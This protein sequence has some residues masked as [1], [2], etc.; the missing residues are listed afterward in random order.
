M[1]SDAGSLQPVC[2]PSCAWPAMRSTFEAR[3]MAAP[4]A[5]S[6]RR[7]FLAGSTA[8]ALHGLRYM[9]RRHGPH[10]T[11]RRPHAGGCRCWLDAS[12]TAW[13]IAGDVVVDP[14]DRRVRPCRSGRS[15]GLAGSVQP[16]PVRARRR[17]RLAPRPRARRRPRPSYLG[18][19]ATARAAQASAAWQRWLEDR[20]RP[21]PAGPE[22]SRAGRPARPSSG[23][24]L[25]AARPASTR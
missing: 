15:H 2:V 1:R 25:P 20:R 18:Q 13:I 17:G 22:R 10:V 23:V 3:A 4:A 9:P 16:A 12:R 7:S 19:D 14:A 6:E 8:G 21:T 5:L 24:G 11:V